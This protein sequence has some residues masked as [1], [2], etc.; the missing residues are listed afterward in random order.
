MINRQRLTIVCR[1]RD[2]LWA[3]FQASVSTPTPP[4][5]EQ[6]SPANLVKIEKRYLFAGKHV[7]EVV[8]VAAESE[9]AKKWPLWRPHESDSTGER[10]EEGR[11]SSATP[12]STPKPTS[13]TRPG[14]RKP[15]TTLPALPT[16]GSSKAKKITTLDKSAMDWRAHVTSQSGDVQNELTA[17]RRGGGF[18]EKVDF[19]QRVQDRRQDVLESSK[20]NKRRKI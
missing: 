9:D 16:P 12:A 13:G 11:P 17:N 5:K 2:T 19:L 18:L 8:E 7:T 3:S 6:E 4:P 10:A 14:P 20:S 15:R 1:E